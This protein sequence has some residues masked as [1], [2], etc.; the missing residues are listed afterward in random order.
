MQQLFIAAFGSTKGRPLP[1]ESVHL[2]VRNK[3]GVDQELDA[4]VVPHI[5]DPITSQMNSSC[6]EIFPHLAGLDLADLP[7]EKTLEVDMLIGSDL[8][9]DFITG[10]TVRG[11]SGLVAVE[12][13]S[14]MGLIRT[15]WAI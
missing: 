3:S 7:P 8:Y 6:S 5:C 10:Q 13:N 14:R 9:W 4:F 15:S 1:C 2:A 11:R 12:T